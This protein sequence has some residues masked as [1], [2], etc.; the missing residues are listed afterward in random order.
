MIGINGTNLLNKNWYNVDKRIWGGT[1][2]DCVP[3]YHSDCGRSSK[4]AAFILLAF[5]KQHRNTRV[6]FPSAPL[7]KKGNTND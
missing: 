5:D 2:F 1:G 6:R 3:S 4:K 7:I